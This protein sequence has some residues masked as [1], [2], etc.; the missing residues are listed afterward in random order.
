MVSKFKVFLNKMALRAILG[1]DPDF[2]GDLSLG[3]N[4]A[5]G[6]ARIPS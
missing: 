6:A 3:G 1:G 4:S 5:R 2:R